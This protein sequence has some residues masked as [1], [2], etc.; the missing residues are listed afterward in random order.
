MTEPY[1]R[2]SEAIGTLE[3][4]SLS[5]LRQKAA[6]SVLATLTPIFESGQSSVPVEEFHTRAAKVFAAARERGLTLSIDPDDPKEVRDECRRWVERDWLERHGEV[7][8]EVY[9]IS[10]EAREAIRIVRE[11]GRTRAALS[12]SQVAAVLARARDLA[13]KVTADPESRMAGLRV[14]IDDMEAKLAARRA[15]LEELEVGGAV[16]LP[17][18]YAVLSELI[19]L[20]EEIDRLPHD[21][22]RVEEEFRSL[23]Q[24]LRNDFLGETRPHGEVIGEY[25]RRADALST[26]DRYGRGFQSAKGLLTDDLAQDQLRHHLETIVSFRFTDEDPIGE[27]DRS[28]LRQTIHLVTKSVSAVLDQRDVLIGRLVGF[29]TRHNALREKELHESL[30]AAKNQLRFWAENN[31]SR[32]TLPLPVGHYVGPDADPDGPV[33]VTGEV[34]IAEVATFRERSMRKRVPTTLVSLTE[35]AGSGAPTFS[36]DDLRAMGGPFYA[37]LADAIETA[38]RIRG[39]IG[40]AELFNGLPEWIRRPVDIFGLLDLATKQFAIRPD[41]PVEEF[42]AV[43][44]DGTS[45]VFLLPQITFVSSSTTTSPR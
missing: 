23:A 12:E 5:L 44:I 33:I 25:L 4:S 32:A 17:D 24:E 30:R 1:A 40:A 38:T 19:S 16:E 28:D 31:T 37:E 2:L 13:L 35:S 43:R 27:H 20:Q 36:V 7:D 21:L 34:G 45:D 18:D 9:R 29:I 42:H 39:A 22:R 14:E 15:E 8:G 3:N 10:P 6:P 11:L 41:M 26:V